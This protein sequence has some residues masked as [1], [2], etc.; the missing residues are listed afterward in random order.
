MDLSLSARLLGAQD[1]M[2]R[3]RREE[4]QEP[5]SQLMLWTGFLLPPIAWSLQL[6]SV[7]LLS[8]YGCAYNNFMPNHIASAALL[9]LSLIGWIIAWLNWQRSGS[10][11]PN[12]GPGAVPRSRFMSA[13][14]LLSGA[15]FSALIFARWLP[16]IVGVQ[17]GK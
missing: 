12:G 1:L 15:L 9:L 3:Q 10:T 5:V 8:D 13:L 11:W 17:C 16:T 7:Y 2:S 14:G 4:L 6:E